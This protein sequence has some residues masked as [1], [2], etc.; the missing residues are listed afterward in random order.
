MELEGLRAQLKVAILEYRQ[1]RPH[2]SIRSTAKN[3]GVDRYFLGKIIEDAPLKGKLDLNKVFVLVQSLGQGPGLRSLID[4]QRPFLKKELMEAFSTLYKEDKIY[5]EKARD[6]DLYDPDLY[7]VLACCTFDLGIDASTLMTILGER[8]KIVIDDLINNEVIKEENGKYLLA[9]GQDFST[10]LNLIK[11]QLP[12]WLRYYRPEHAGQQRN[13]IYLCAQG[14]NREALAK[15]QQLQKEFHGRLVE[16]INQPE[17]FGS[18]PFFS[19]G[20]TDTLIETI[21]ELKIKEEDANITGE[22]YQ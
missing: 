2:L 12:H 6:L 15:A 20:V 18:I 1:A 21:P 13:Y 5:S 8:A 17:S 9:D 10:T 4:Q 19:F 7:L 22:I 3:L 11:S 16:L 14:L